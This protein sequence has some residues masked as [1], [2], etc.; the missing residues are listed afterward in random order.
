[1]YPHD[2]VISVLGPAKD[3]SNGRQ[4]ETRT[5]IHTLLDRSPSSPM[6]T[7]L[8]AAFSLDLSRPYRLECWPYE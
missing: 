2:L 4:R 1:M 7:R 8:T 6:V 3:R 5:L